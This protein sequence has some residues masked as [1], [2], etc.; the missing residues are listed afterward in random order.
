MSRAP[1]RLVLTG[2]PGSGKTVMLNLLAADPEFAWLTFLP[3]LARQL[4]NQDPAYRNRWDEFHL[5]LYKRQTEREEQLNGHSFVTDRGTVDA[6]G[7]HPKS[8]HKVGSNLER[9]YS[10]Y[11]HVLLLETSAHLG[12]SYY[13][14]DQIRQESIEDALAIEQALATAWGGHPELI[15][16]TANPDFEQKCHSVVTI[17]HGLVQKSPKPPDE[18]LATT[19]GWD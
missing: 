1:V 6:F 14:M 19:S 10:R 3:E 2:A 15:R 18:L 4:L 13:Q 7:F 8:L 11:T 12:A 5:E 9:E 16:I 17:M